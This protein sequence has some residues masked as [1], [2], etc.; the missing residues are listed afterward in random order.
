MENNENVINDIKTQ[1]TEIC[2]NVLFM[3]FCSKTYNN[4]KAKFESCL[5]YNQ[6]KYNLKQCVLKFEEKKED[7][8]YYGKI[9]IRFNSFDEFYFIEFKVTQ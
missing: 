9:N 3:P 7:M 4:L 8:C 6:A 5:S 1:I 2:E